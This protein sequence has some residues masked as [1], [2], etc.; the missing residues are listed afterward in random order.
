MYELLI[1]NGPMTASAVRSSS[2]LSPAQVRTG[3]RTLRRLGLVALE[4]D[5]PVRYSAVSPDLALGPLLLGVERQLTE[6]R[7]QTERLAQH[8]RRAAADRQPRDLVEVVHGAEAI[9]RRADQVMRGARHIVRFIDKPPYA[10]LQRSL[11]PVEA[12]LLTRGVTVQ[13]IYDRDGLAL[14]D[15]RADLEAGLALG[16]Q[17]RVIADAPTKMIIADDALGLIPLRATPAVMES[18][19]VVQQSALLTALASLFVILWRDAVPLALPGA[20]PGPRDGVPSEQDKRLL[21]LLTTGM[22]DRTIAKQLGLSY[23]TFPRRRHALM[24]ALDAD[25]RFQAGLRAAARGWVTVPV[26]RRR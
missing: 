2:R 25:T 24:A 12:E 26:S 20:S 9:S 7:N 18:A 17:A 13:G 15:L 11:H 14:H 6:A 16:E 19:V 21:A 22:P 4:G 3:L 10:Q 5:T 8:Y 1:G 23:R